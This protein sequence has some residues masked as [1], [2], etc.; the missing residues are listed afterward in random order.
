MGTRANQSLTTPSGRPAAWGTRVREKIDTTLLVDKLT[1][2]VKGDIEMTATQVNAARILLDRTV[3]VLK[4]LE[5]T[6]NQDTDIRTITNSDLI[7]V[8]TSKRISNGSK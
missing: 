1:A 5:V 8:I 2:H 4:A 6:T 3:P 7:G